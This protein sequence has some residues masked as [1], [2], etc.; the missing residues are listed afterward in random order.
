MD[1]L[2]K[3]IAIGLCACLL[4]GA[5]MAEETSTT[6]AVS[7]A[8][9]NVQNAGQE[10]GQKPPDLP[11]GEG[12]NGFDGQQPPDMSGSSDSTQENSDGQNA[13]SKPAG[14]KNGN[15]RKP[16]AK[17]GN[18]EAGHPGSSVV[19]IQT[20]NNSGLRMR[21]EASQKSR[22]VGEFPNGTVVE[23]L[24]VDGE[25]AKVRIGNQEGYVMT[26]YLEGDLAASAETRLDFEQLLK[27]GVID[28]ELYEKIMNYMKER[29]PQGQPGGTAPAKGS[30]P[31]AAPD[32]VQ[33]QQQ[34]G[35]EEQ[36]LK[37]LLDNEIL[38]QEQ[39]NLI[40]AKI[41]DSAAVAVAETTETGT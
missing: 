35:M 7:G 17:A 16:P 36:L 25:W 4:A 18:G 30:K 6:D 33:G 27:D 23:V 5:A 9:Q 37:E 12:Q 40:L 14:K 19:R 15:G 3:T 21:K 11:D 29:T 13:S 22:I 20:G 41:T 34:G 39:Y 38:T 8:T 1:H 10:G 26:K 32:G 2:K 28:Q 24:E 31:P